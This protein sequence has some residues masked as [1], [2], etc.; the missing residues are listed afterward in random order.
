M[1]GQGVASSFKFGQ[2]YGTLRMALV[3]AGI[4]FDTVTPQKRQ[5]VMH[6]MSK[7]DKNVTKRRAQELFPDITI[8]HAKADALLIAA[9]GWSVRTG[10]PY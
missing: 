10:V 8:T 3:A 6:C 5:H 2:N 7:G 4:P 9:Y 1:P